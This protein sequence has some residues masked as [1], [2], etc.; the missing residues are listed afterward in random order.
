MQQI[1]H[2]FYTMAFLYA[3]SEGKPVD[4]CPTM[5]TI[6]GDCGPGKSTFSTEI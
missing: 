3:G 5:R 1:A 6:I 4:L 2:L